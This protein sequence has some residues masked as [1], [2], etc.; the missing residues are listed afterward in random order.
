M[1][2]LH[3]LGGSSHL[4]LYASECAF[5]YLCFSLHFNLHRNGQLKYITKTNGINV[6]FLFI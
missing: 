3:A 4:N 5:K 6:T 2:A 1:V